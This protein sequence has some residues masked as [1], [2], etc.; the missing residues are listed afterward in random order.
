MWLS[1]SDDPIVARLTKRFDLM[2]NLDQSLSEQLQ[3][4]NYGLG[5]HYEPHYDMA[6]VHFVILFN[7]ICFIFNHFQEN[8]RLDLND[9]V[10]GNRIATLLLYVSIDY[11][12]IEI[13]I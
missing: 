10:H 1:E 7:F 4:A 12:M 6:T 5:G 11:I 8:E 13:N 3:I 2:T 9:D